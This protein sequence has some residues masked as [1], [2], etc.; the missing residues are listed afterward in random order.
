MDRP[1]RPQQPASLQTELREW[2]G[3]VAGQRIL[4]RAQPQLERWVPQLFGYHAVQ[5]G[6]VDPDQDLLETSRILHRLKVDPG[7]RSAGVYAVPDQLPF[8]TDSLDLVLLVHALEFTQQP[9]QVLRELDRVLVPEGHVLILG[10]NPLSLFGLW[11]LALGW[12]GRIPWCGRFYSPYRVKDWLALLGFRALACEY[13]GFAPPAQRHSV[14]RRLAWV[15]KFGSRWWRYLG[16]AYIILARKQV[17]TLTPIKPRWR[18]RRSIL[19]GNLTEPSTRSMH[20][21]R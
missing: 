20:H 16:G 17:T 19:A 4:A 14:L 18:P 1:R 8:Q 12:R 10:F 5:I 21:D 2:Y 7:S 3:S 9:H 13:V 15:E 11:K 6:D